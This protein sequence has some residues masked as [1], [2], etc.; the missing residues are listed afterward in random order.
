M[1]KYLTPYQKDLR[2]ADDDDLPD[3]WERAHGL[4]PADPSGQN[5]AWG[6]PDGDFL[7]NFREYQAGLDPQKQDVHGAPGFAL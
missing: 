5:G 3:D 7:E 1:P 4:N 6:D 2:D